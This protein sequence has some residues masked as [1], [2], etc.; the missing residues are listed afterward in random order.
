MLAS[1][2]VFYP[3]AESIPSN[4]DTESW[5]SDNNEARRVYDGFRFHFGGEEIILIGLERD[6]HSDT[7]VEALCGRLERLEE[8]RQVWSPQ[9]FEKLMSGFGLSDSEIEQRLRRVAVSSDGKLAGVAVLLTD[10]GLADRGTT[11]SNVYDVLE[12]CQLKP[13]DLHLTGAPVIVAELDRLGGKETNRN[14]FLVTMAICFCV[15]WWTLKQFKPAGLILLSTV[16]AFQLTLAIVYLLGGEMNFILDSLPVMVM[17]F[18][19]AV[20]THY[21]YHFA[22]HMRDPDPVGITLRGVSWPCFLAMFTTAI[23]LCSLRISEMP[24]IRQFGIATAG[25]TLAAFIAGLGITPAIL[26]LHPPIRFQQKCWQR[27]FRK[28]ASELYVGRKR[29]A[30]GVGALVLFCGTGL[31]WTKAEFQPLNFFPDDSKVL[32]DTRLIQKQLSNTD[33]VE[34]VVDF[35]SASRTEVSK[36]ETI[37]VIERELLKLA[38]VPVVVSAATFLPDPLP[39][40]LAGLSAFQGQSSESDFVADGGH[41]WRI[42]AR[43]QPEGDETQQVLF[44]RI[45]AQMAVVG[46]SENVSIVCTGIAPLIERAQQDIFDGF[47]KSVVMA[48]FLI[49]VIMMVALRSVSAGIVAMVPN[50]TPILLVFGCLGW[51]RIPTDIGTMMTGSIALGIAVD[52]TFH[53]LTRYRSM[54]RETGN[55][56]HAT[57]VALEQT[58]PPIVQ[59]TIITG[60]GMLALGLS[61]FGPT[62]RFGLLMTASL[63]VALIGDL[64]LLPCLLFMRPRSRRQSAL[65]EEAGDVLTV[66]TGTEELPAMAACDAAK[67][68][69]ESTSQCLATIEALQVLIEEELATDKF[70]EAVDGNVDPSDA[71]ESQGRSSEIKSPHFS[72]KTGSRSR[73]RQSRQERD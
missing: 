44:E 46:A 6:Q 18:A 32:S 65:R 43:T 20:S 71:N 70:S 24:P 37:R 50:V 34:V 30:L 40:G 27:W 36:V 17:V 47:W 68:E 15:L 28:L 1:L 51:L 39:Q 61:N 8:V 19:M 63:T 21:L 57:R 14:Y 54:Y 45:S 11:V 3:L 55:T 25:G 42:S 67:V 13:S 35:G 26:T 49:T 58:G 7:F 22:A 56:V 53:F 12:Y 52:G 64:I 4:N 73:Q 31:Y 59:A 66:E 9:R 16:W 5:L 23:G 72:D 69:F 41:L 48:F 10:A 60:L 62:V 2:A 38:R 33:S 29:T